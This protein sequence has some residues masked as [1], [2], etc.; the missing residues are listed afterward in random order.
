TLTQARNAIDQ[1]IAAGKTDFPSAP[2]NDAIGLKFDI[3]D[4]LDVS[5]GD[6]IDF[7]ALSLLYDQDNWGLMTYHRDHIFPQKA[8]R[9]GILP[10]GLTPDQQQQYRDAKDSIANLQLLVDTENAEKSGK[11][12]EE[13]I[14][15]TSPDYRKKHLIPQDDS[16]LKFDKFLE[17][18]EAREELIRDRLATILP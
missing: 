15:G 14:A 3:D 4:Y 2:I 16:L 13:W 1:H 17:F 5:Y 9:N 10:A 6:K 8:F 18:I 12:F 7:L 11:S